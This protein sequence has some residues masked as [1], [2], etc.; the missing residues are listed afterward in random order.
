MYSCLLKRTTTRFPRLLAGAILI[1]ALSTFC[2]CAL[3]AV[4]P[5]PL[6]SVESPES[7]SMEA[8]ENAPVEGTPWW[9]AFSD[10]L[11]NGLIETALHQNFSVAQAVERIDRAQ[12]ILRQ[13]N[14]VRFP[15]IGLDADVERTRE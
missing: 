11:L 1:P 13:V 12:A 5:D 9:E 6:P 4:N 3:H 2:G 10:P 7:F 14:A 15:L 8:G